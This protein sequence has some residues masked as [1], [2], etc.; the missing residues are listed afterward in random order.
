MSP[1][2]IT[3]MLQL[4]FLQIT[5][6]PILGAAEQQFLLSASLDTA[7]T[8]VEDWLCQQYAC[9]EA[10]RRQRLWRLVSVRNCAASPV[11]RRR[12]PRYRG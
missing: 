3:C 2:A 1:N 8:V 7:A 9:A 12:H 11:R 5:I 4:T 10:Q 6:H